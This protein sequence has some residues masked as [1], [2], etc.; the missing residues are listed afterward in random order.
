M[1]AE[2]KFEPSVPKPFAGQYRFSISEY[3][4]GAR[5]DGGDLYINYYIYVPAHK[6][7][8]SQPGNILEV[9]PDTFMRLEQ[10]ARRKGVTDLQIYPS[11]E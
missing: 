1:L 11:F 5:A 3:Y 10:E 8:F 4:P 2:V 9:D 7:S 6:V